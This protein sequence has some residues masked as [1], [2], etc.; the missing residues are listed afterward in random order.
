MEVTGAVGKDQQHRF[1]E[2]VT[3][4]GTGRVSFGSELLDAERDQ[5]NASSSSGCNE[6]HDPNEKASGDRFAVKKM[7]MCQRYCLRESTL[8][9]TWL[10]RVEESFKN[11]F[12]KVDV[13]NSSVKTATCGIYARGCM[14]SSFQMSRLVKTCFRGGQN[15]HFLQKRHG[16]QCITT[17]LN[18]LQTL[19][20]TDS[21]SRT[22]GELTPSDHL[23]FKCFEHFLNRF[24]D[25][26]KRREEVSKAITKTRKTI[27]ACS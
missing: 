2:E 9:R 14:W 8:L 25:E 4:H 3:S 10:T 21:V 1:H 20:G 11:T 6:S 23:V 16:K 5:Q 24:L 19:N 15:S 13:R 7:M 27:I 17:N 18:C 12:G 26:V 22:T